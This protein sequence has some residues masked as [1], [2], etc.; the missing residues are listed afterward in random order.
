MMGHG[1]PAVAQYFNE[2]PPG[3]ATRRHK[4]MA[5]PV[6]SVNEAR[7][8]LPE[9]AGFLSGCVRVIFSLPS[10]CLLGFD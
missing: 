10:Y 2:M 7:C 8:V 6:D 3:G 5:G 9:I 1:A 4:G